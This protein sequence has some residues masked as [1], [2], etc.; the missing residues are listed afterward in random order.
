MSLTPNISINVSEYRQ[1]LLSQDPELVSMIER[2]IENDRSAQEALYKRYYGK[3]MSLCLR[4]VKERD[5]A[6][7]VLNLGFLKVFKS[8]SGYT[9]SGSFDGWIHRIV[10]H[11]II[12]QL[13]VKMKE[14]KTS[15]IEDA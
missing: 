11:S 15:E 3:M 14:M 10:Y 7:S 4:Y 12:D 9:Y 2:C 1:Q 8:L 13:R 5:D 6:L